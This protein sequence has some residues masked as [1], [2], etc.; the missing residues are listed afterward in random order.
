ML[1]V[2][3]LMRKELPHILISEFRTVLLYPMTTVRDMSI[4]KE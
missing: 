4:I 3:K 2:L 1:T